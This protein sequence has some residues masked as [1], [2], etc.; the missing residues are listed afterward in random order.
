MLNS[1]SQRIKHSAQVNATGEECRAA[2]VQKQVHREEGRA[3]SA[4]QRADLCTLCFCSP[5]QT[6]SSRMMVYQYRAGR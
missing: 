1:P 3:Q 4:K 5:P 6:S 2:S